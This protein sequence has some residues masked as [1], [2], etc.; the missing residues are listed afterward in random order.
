ML[1]VA[2]LKFAI[3][4]WAGATLFFTAVLMVSDL[5]GHKP[6]GFAL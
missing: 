5:G 1:T 6:F 4:G 3:L 2:R